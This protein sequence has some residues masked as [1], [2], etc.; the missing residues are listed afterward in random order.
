MNLDDWGNE[1]GDSW[2]LLNDDQ[3]ERWIRDRIFAQEIAGWGDFRDRILAQE[4]TEWE[5]FMEYSRNYEVGT[6]VTP[7]KHSVWWRDGF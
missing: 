7:V 1:Y 6:D 5:D 2:Q 4:I 3:K